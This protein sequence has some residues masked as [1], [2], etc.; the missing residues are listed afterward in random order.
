VH[1]VGCRQ[2][3]AKAA[4]DCRSPNLAEVRTRPKSRS[5]LL[6]A[7][8][9][10]L[11]NVQGQLGVKIASHHFYL[12]ALA[13]LTFR[14]SAQPATLPPVP[15][16][17]EYP[18]GASNEPT[19]FRK[20]F[21]AQPS[22]LKAILLGACNGQM[23]LY[24]NGQTLGEIRSRDVAS[25]I[26]VTEKVQP[27]AN[28]LSIRALGS[29]DS[30]K[31]SLLLELNGD[32]AKNRWIASDA[33]WLASTNESATATWQRAHSLG[34][35]DALPISNPF[36]AK[37]A[38]DAYNS[39]KLA[40]GTN[41]ATDPRTFT[42]RPGFKGELLRSSQAGEG[43]WV[44]MAFDPK[45]RLT[46][47]RENRGLLRLTLGTGAVQRVE[48]I[49]DTLLE[50][51]GLLY[52]HN[53]LYVNA[54]NSKGFYRLRDT[55]GNDRFDE[56]KL[57]LRTGG[58][59]GHGRNHVVLGPD[60]SIWLVHGNN[61]TLAENVPTNSPLQ[62][63]KNDAL[64]PCPFDDAMFDG[65]V[66]LPA[67]HILRT[68]AEGTRFELFAGGFRNPLD[69][70][71]NRAGEMFTFDADMEW[72]VGSPWYRPNRINHVISGA[73]FGWRR[74]TAKYPDYFPD[75]LPSTLDIGLASPTGIEFGTRSH[76]PHPY[77]D[78]LFIADWAYGRILTVYLVPTGATYT[79]TSELFVS[80]RPFNVTDLTFGPNGAMYVIT[81]GRGTQSGLYRISYV[82][83]KPKDY[84]RSLS[85]ITRDSAGAAARRLRR[86]LEAFHNP[87]N[88]LPSERVIDLV[89]PHLGHPDASIR[90]AA[91]IG[92]EHQ[93]VRLWQARAL[94]EQQ[95]EIALTASLALSRVASHESERALLDRLNQLSLSSLTPDQQLRAL[96]VYELAC[97]RMGK[98]DPDLLNLMRE[99]IEPLYPAS[100]WHL[101][102][103][104]CALLVYLHSPGVV[105]K[106]IDLLTV[107][108]RPEDLM[109]YLFYLR[110]VREGWSIEQR[111]AWFGGLQRAEQKQ[112]ARDYYSV[113]K[114]V[115]EDF[116]A[117]LPREQLDQ[118]LA[119]GVIRASTPSSATA[120]VGP[121]APR[122]RAGERG[123]E[124]SKNQQ[125]NAAQLSAPSGSAQIKFV[126][127]WRM[128]D[129]DVSQPLT[130]RSFEKG[131]AAFRV[132]QCI[133]CH[134]FGNEGGLAGPDLS[135]VGSRFDRRALLE[136]VLEPSK[137]IDEKFRNTRFTLKNG[138]SIAGMVEREDPEKLSVR[139][140]PFAEKV[141][142]LV[143]A[144]I[145]RREPSLVSPMPEGLVN[146]LDREGILD[147][148]AL[149]E[150]GV[151]K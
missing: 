141:I 87:T 92:L 139:E 19:F 96:R 97:S 102:H 69:I 98:P 115:R 101:N 10:L 108:E 29:N 60:G 100:D 146:I 23:E 28:L 76:F 36:D 130:G 145:V 89:W 85:E 4:E 77:D 61:V 40:L 56:V 45:G 71:F 64:I 13:C 43:S 53:A 118:L 59:V 35:V 21:E 80:G 106:T 142:E 137:V 144:N 75:T 42:L 48:L 99:K 55:D 50:C 112:G 57:L 63:Y 93:D 132:A 41:S 44:S 150:S 38:F 88:S 143:K 103:R 78:A 127:E 136:S 46:L 122:E 17:I 2:A 109:Q 8:A 33:T 79:A 114:R 82:A 54:N 110:Y 58:G 26:D 91:R 117:S 113:L 149:L 52:A 135:A 27:G 119:K 121:L 133:L 67:G 1:T 5:L 24:L 83:A 151:R 62:L 116:V 68:D 147:L 107:T 11:S 120:N 16:W 12:I 86:E 94:S 105:A 32:L 73:D 37:K 22:L 9:G 111:E 74:G 138:T 90:H 66:L 7:G 124:L 134:R 81:G 31:V 70:A 15:E 25:G 148:L 126:K 129:F 30:A 84:V 20:S 104:L 131:M 123:K 49:N 6:D 125:A 51:R 34:R 47:A 95:T 14:A 3:E 72:D 128:D 65:D 18:A 39:W 140:T